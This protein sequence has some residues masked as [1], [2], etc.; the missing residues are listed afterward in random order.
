MLPSFQSNDYLITNIIGYRFSAPA[1]GQVIIL[2]YPKDTSEYFIKRIIGLPGE[3][4][5][6]QEGRVFIN[7]SPL[8]ESNYL[9]PSVLTP[10]GAFLREG[11]EFTIPI[12]NYIVMGD[13]RPNSSD[14]REWGLVPS[15]DIIGQAF[16]RYFP[17]NEI[18]LI[19][20]GTY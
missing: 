5:K 6:V 8:N 12:D 13:N 3:T 2:K 18:G 10:P 11:G 1:R 4:V 9:S 15:K 7:G 14:S 20:S 19:K 17:S 16:F